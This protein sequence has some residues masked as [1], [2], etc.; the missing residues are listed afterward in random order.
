MN[1][2]H[3]ENI[4]KTTATILSILLLAGCASSGNYSTLKSSEPTQVS[5]SASS[6]DFPQKCT[7]CGLDPSKVSKKTYDNPI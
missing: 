6:G 3:K 5:R 7:N 1:S 2:T 4:M